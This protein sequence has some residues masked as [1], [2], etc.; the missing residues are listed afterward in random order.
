MK[1]AIE[2][3]KQEHKEEIQLMQQLITE[4]TEKSVTIQSDEIRNRRLVESR[5]AQE[6]KKVRS[7]KNTSTVAKQYYK[8]MAKL[9]YVDA[10]FMDRKK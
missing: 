10:Q 3:E 1:A 8:N 7:K 9:N 6:R 2:T 5:F 4:I